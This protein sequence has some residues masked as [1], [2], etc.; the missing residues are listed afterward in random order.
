MSISER[1]ITSLTLEEINEEI[2]R[3][4]NLGL[5]GSGYGAPE[6][7]G[8]HDRKLQVLMSLREQKL[9]DIQLE[10]ATVSPQKS[11]A[12]SVQGNETFSDTIVRLCNHCGNVTSQT[13]VHHHSAPM[14]FDTIKGERI[15]EEFIF[16][17]FVCSTCQGLNLMGGFLVENGKTGDFPELY[18]TGSSLTPAPYLVPGGELIPARLTEIYSQTW[19]LKKTNPIAFVTQ[20]RRALEYICYDQGATGRSLASKLQNL[21]QKGVFPGHIGDVTD[22]LR[23]I[24]NIGAHDSQVEVTVWD[25]ESIDDFFRLLVEYVYV[26]AAKIG[27]VRQLVT[28]AKQQK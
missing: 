14:L 21:I 3:M 5:D 7:W 22:L 4:T 26:I 10:N 16:K 9:R 18:P 24:G 12:S 13:L 27:I 6:A 17:S 25:A 23:L 15:F 1:Q 28:K 11:V 20:I 8:A 19:P 2:D